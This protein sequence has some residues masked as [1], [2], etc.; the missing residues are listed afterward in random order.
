MT[1]LELCCCC[2]LVLGFVEGPAVRRTPLMLA[3][4]ERVSP[5]QRGAQGASVRRKMVKQ[6]RSAVKMDN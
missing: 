2:C 4:G 3:V 6:L 1:W 5:V